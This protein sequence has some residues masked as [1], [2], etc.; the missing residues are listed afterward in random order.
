MD[1]RQQYSTTLSAMMLTAV[2]AISSGR[3]EASLN[4]SSVILAQKSAGDT[5]ASSSLKASCTNQLGT[6]VSLVDGAKAA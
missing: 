1:S 6:K 4:F 3:N 2:A 5:Y